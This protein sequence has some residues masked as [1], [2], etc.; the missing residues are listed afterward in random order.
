MRKQ[1]VWMLVAVLCLAA[2]MGVACGSK[3]APKP[4]V[5][6]VKLTDF[7]VEMDKTDIPA[8]P[9]QFMITNSG[10]ITHE[11]VLERAGAV[12]APFESN[13]KG[14]EA[15]DIKVGTTSTLEWT[16]DEPGQYQLACHV[17]GH[18]EAGMVQAFTVS[19]P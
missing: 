1:T 12:D 4:T 3:A 17:P 16:I 9:V 2:L 5:V 13:G 18:F 14:S 8:G 6:N 10:T 15:E 11:L 7:K 19:K